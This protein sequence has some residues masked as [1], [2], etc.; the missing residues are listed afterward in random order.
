MLP[1]P[2][3]ATRSL[4]CAS[5]LRGVAARPAVEALAQPV[6]AY[7]APPALHPLRAFCVATRGFT[8]LRPEATARPWTGVQVKTPT[9]LKSGEI[10]MIC[11]LNQHNREEFGQFVRSLPPLDH[12]EAALPLNHETT[13]HFAA[14]NELSARKL[15]RIFDRY[16]DG[17][18]L[19]L[20][21][22]GLGGRD[23]P[24]RLLA[25][26]FCTPTDRTTCSSWGTVVV[27]D[28]RQ[29]GVGSA[30]LRAQFEAAAEKGFRSMIGCP[31][32][33][34]SKTLWRR[35]C[36]DLGL[37]LELERHLIS[38][39][40]PLHWVVRWTADLGPIAGKRRAQE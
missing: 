37:K 19:V 23:I 16:A 8:D 13:Q 32:D 36:V 22:R 20:G 33:D 9:I 38:G 4:T 35:V 24:P 12:D 28:M 31:S 1:I 11:S 14:W 21:V 34:A 17:G 39:F 2:R 27:K 29:Q 15:T 26:T 18:G 7:L 3:V 6:P 5:G 25:L 10:G 40:E 30:L